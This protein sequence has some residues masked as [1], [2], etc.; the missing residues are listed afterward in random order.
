MEES[1]FLRISA[2]TVT[3]TLKIGKQ[4]FCMTLLVMMMY[5]HITFHEER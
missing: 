3:L 2:R 1:Y 4:P 5:H